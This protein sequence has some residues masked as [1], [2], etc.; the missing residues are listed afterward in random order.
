[1]SRAGGVFTVPEGDEPRAVGFPLGEVVAF[2]RRAPDKDG[3][4]NEDAAA[5]VAAEVGG[6]LLVAD[7]MGGRS[8]GRR[9]SR[10]V[11]ET[12]AE[13]VARAEG[14]GQA[15]RHA[16]L[17][18]IE[19]AN[20]AVRE[21]GLGAGATV[22]AI[23]L[24]GGNARA[25]HVGDAVVMHVGQRGLL[26]AVTVPHSPTGYGVEA[27]LLDVDEAM[28][29]EERHLVLNYVGHEGM[30]I[31]VG[32]KVGVASRDTLLVASDGL[33]DNLTPEEIVATARKGPLLEAGQRLAGRA[34]SRMAGRSE[35]APSKPDDLTFLLFRP[36]R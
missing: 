19:A 24:S 3:D 11:V 6:L 36:R 12:V 14:A 26:K 8:A 23:A 22:A 27:G 13:R 34:R 32:A 20:A 9:A 29:H 16:V 15:L 25:F 33:A 17:D 2:T 10:L 28:V 21:L 4:A 30:R 5:V 7:G 1:M 18:G 35:A 31:E